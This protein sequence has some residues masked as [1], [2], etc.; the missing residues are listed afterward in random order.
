MSLLPSSRVGK[1]EFFEAHIAPWTAHATD[2]GLSSGS[3]ANLTSQTAAAR[4]AFLAAEEARN[5]SKAATQAFYTAVATMAKSGTEM[6]EMIRTYASVN[7]DP[8]A[9]DLAQI[10]PPSAGSPIGPPGIPFQPVV[11]LSQTGA[12]TL[13]WKCVNPTNAVGTIY[14]VRRRVGSSGD[15]VMI[16]ASGAKE[17]ED[18]T[19]PSGAGQVAYQV[20]GLRSTVRGPVAEFTV[21]FGVAGPTVTSTTLTMAA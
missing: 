10:A 21:R 9:Y 16:G 12:I 4:A 6:I 15:F 3:V 19:L 2:V 8:G 17:F 1:I 14:E 7:N 11:T 18:A 5:A 13:A 20:N